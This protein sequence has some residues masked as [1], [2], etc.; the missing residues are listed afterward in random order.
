MIKRRPI[1]VGVLSLIISFIVFAH[2]VSGVVLSVFLVTINLLIIGIEGIVHGISGGRNMATT[3]T[4]VAYG[5]WITIYHQKYA[6]A[7]R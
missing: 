7:L 3:S 4:S 6:I 2:P 1:D 5:K